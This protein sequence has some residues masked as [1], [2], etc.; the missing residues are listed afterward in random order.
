MNKAF[1]IALVD[2]SETT[3]SEAHVREDLFV[4]DL[5]ISQ[6]EGDFCALQIEVENPRVGLLA[7]G[8]P[9]WIWVAWNPAFDPLASESSEAVFE[10]MVPLFFGRVQGVPSDFI[11]ETVTL[12]FLARPLDYQAQK[13]AV[14]DTLRVF[15]WFDGVWFAPEDRG[16]ADNVLE[17]RAALWHIDRVSHDVTVSNIITGEDGTIMFDGADVLNDT[18]RISYGDP[19]CRQVNVTANFAWDQI[20]SGEMWVIGTPSGLGI[21]YQIIDTYTGAGLQENWP[22]SG[23]KIGGDWEVKTSICIRADTT[24]RDTWTYDYAQTIFNQA[25]KGKAVTVPSWAVRQTVLN[26]TFPAHVLVI[27]KWKVQCGLSVG[28]SSKRGKAETV[29]FSLRSDTQSILTDSTDGEAINLTFSSSEIAQPVDVVASS[30]ELELPIGKP[31]ARSYAT[32]DR[33]AKSLEY[34]ILVAR[35][36][37]LASARCVDV[38]FEVSWNRAIEENITLRKNVVLSDP[39]IPGGVAGGKVKS[40]TLN[41]NGDS[42]AF[43]AEITIGCCIGRGNTITADEEGNGVYAAPGY[44]S[45]G[46][47]RYE[48]AFVFPVAGEVAYESINGIPPVDDGVDFDRMIPARMLLQ[49]VIVT[50]QAP[51]QE[52]FIT[53]NDEP[54][55]VYEKLN[56]MQTGVSFE[57]RPLNSGPFLD[58]YAIATTL[59]AVPKT[60]DLE[61]DLDSSS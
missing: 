13:E 45:R 32:T 11:G 43:T 57:L 61:A 20:A 27:K 9:R 12:N 52:P 16:L 18:I 4:T 51:A 7:P 58:R 49:P 17:S 23:A 37:L 3:F 47:Q 30:G 34:L 35:A 54:A 44:M 36:R 21:S 25:D 22:K 5:S 50:N 24:G 28:F 15:P 42:G 6:A 53:T 41:A 60:I 39:S 10:D 1:S 55:K 33:G 59:L 46:Y 26:V 29:T 19:P 40:Y 31:W 56:T 38:T 8:R 14:A 2:E 48:N